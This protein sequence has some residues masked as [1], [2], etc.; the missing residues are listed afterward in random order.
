[1]I[2]PW[3]AQMHQLSIVSWYCQVLGVAVLFAHC[4][5]W[6]YNARDIERFWSHLL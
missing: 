1:M 2:T 3:Y 5:W 6:W 4:C